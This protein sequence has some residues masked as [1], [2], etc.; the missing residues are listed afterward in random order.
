M[1]DDGQRR[2]RFYVMD[3]A[4][5]AE[6]ALTYTRG[7]DQAAF[8]ADDL[9]YDATLRNLELIGEAATRIPAEVR[10]QHD[11]IPWRMVIALRNRLIH[12]D[13]GLDNDTLW[14]IVQDDV[15]KPRQQLHR[16]LGN[17]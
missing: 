7:L 10:D 11:E 3:M 9:V 14:S 15:P 4:Q 16:M 17:S 5:F 12:G 8:V 1:S 6:K 2:W 13:L